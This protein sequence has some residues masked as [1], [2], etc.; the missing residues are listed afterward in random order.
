MSQ[1]Y[2]KKKKTSHH[3]YDVILHRLNDYQMSIEMRV[4]YRQRRRSKED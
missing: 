1:I 3:H 2:D 4:W